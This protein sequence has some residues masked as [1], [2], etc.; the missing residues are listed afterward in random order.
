MPP[1]LVIAAEAHRNGDAR[2]NYYPWTD[3]ER[4]FVGWR[5]RHDDDSEEFIYL[6]PSLDGD[7]SCAIFRGTTGDPNQDTQIGLT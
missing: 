6:V 5:L 4:R 3:A 1:F 2:C 7:A